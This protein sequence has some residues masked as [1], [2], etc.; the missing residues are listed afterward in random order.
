MSLDVSVVVP[1]Y[2]RP[3]QLGGCL[4]ALA[5]QDVDR[6]RFEVVVVDDGSPTSPR[7]AVADHEDRLAVRLLRQDN[8]GPAAARNRG[9]HAARGR[10]LAFTDDDCRPDPGW[11]AALLVA[12]ADVPDA[13]LGG[14]TVN[15]LPDNPSAAASQ[16]LVDHLYD[17]YR[18]EARGR[19]YTSN[20]LALPADGFHDLGGFDTSF[21][22]PAGEDRDLCDRWRAAGR[23]DRYVP[24]AVV[25]HAHH[26]R[27]TGF[28][29][30]HLQYGRGAW[31]FARARQR[32]GESV[33]VEPLEFYTTLLRAPWAR[34][35]SSPATI[36]ALIAVAQ[37]ANVVGY[38]LEAA[39]RR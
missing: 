21:G 1:T 34:G 39:R 28:V 37:A 32:R 22:Y 38:A 12:N 35:L 31:H 8:A 13:L 33:P 18:D 2:D 27:L 4:A 5:R 9:A 30:Q 24:D 20:N 36:T 6:D 19:F 29:R 17:W 26:M 23:P 25:R 16:A 3:E 15:D 11:L 7:A 14:R 10:L